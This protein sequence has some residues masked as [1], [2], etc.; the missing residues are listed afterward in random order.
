[1]KKLLIV[2]LALAIQSLS[3]AAKCTISGS[4]TASATTCNTL[5]T[6]DTILIT[7]R[8]TLTSSYSVHASNDIVFIID[9]GSITWDASAD[10][11][12]GLNSKFIIINGGALNNGAGACNPAKR[13]S[14]GGTTIVS[15]GG[16]GGAL[17]SFADYNTAGGGNGIGPLP[18]ELVKFEVKHQGGYNKLFWVTASEY[19][20]SHFEIQNS[21]DGINFITIA[22]IAGAGNSNQLND[23]SYVDSSKSIYYYRLKQIDFNNSFEYSQVI[24]VSGQKDVSPNLVSLLPNPSTGKIK[25]EVNIPDIQNIQVTLYDK[26]GKKILTQSTTEYSDGNTIIN[27]DLSYLPADIY[28]VQTIVDQKVIVTKLVKL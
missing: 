23:Y 1:M 21:T 24:K 4:V 3:Y 19:N 8:L 28:F 9:G 13:I 27:F 6:G 18:V 17:Y 7:G 22:K 20:N 14:F 25:I 5:T 16:G 12:V 2:C 11:D 10:L 15:C 26:H